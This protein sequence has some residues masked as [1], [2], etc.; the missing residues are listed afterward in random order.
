MAWKDIYEQIVYNIESTFT[1]RASAAYYVKQA[2]FVLVDLKTTSEDGVE[3]VTY[4][5]PKMEKFYNWVLHYWDIDETRKLMVYQINN[6]T[7]KN[8]GDLTT[9]V[10]SITWTDGCVPHN[11]AETTEQSRFDTSG[12]IVCS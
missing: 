5:L 10:N 7:E 8:Y 12:W 11:W 4:L 9:F 1:D 3:I 6:F 2:M